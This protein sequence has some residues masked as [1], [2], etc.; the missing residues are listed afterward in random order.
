MVIVTSVTLF[1]HTADLLI[2]LLAQFVMHLVSYTLL[3]LMLAFLC[4]GAICYLQIKNVLEVICD[5]L[6]RL[7]AKTSTTLDVLCPVLFVEKH[8]IKPLKL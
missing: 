5:R 6:E 7:L 4:K 8:T 3:D 1:H 2:K